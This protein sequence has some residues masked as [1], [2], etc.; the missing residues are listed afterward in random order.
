MNDTNANLWVTREA[1]AGARVPRIC[2]PT[3]RSFNRRAYQC[4][5]YEAQDVLAE[6]DDV[7]LI[8]LEPG[9]GFRLRESWQR[10]LVYRDASRRLVYL[11]PGLRR[12]T[13]EREYDLFVMVCQNHWDLLYVNAMGRWKDRCKVSVC[14]LDELWAAD[15]SSCK[16]WLHALRQFDHVFIGLWGTVGPLSEAI[17]RNCQW[18]PGAVDAFRFSPY[19]G[20]PSRSID[21]YSIGRRWEGMHEALL[22]AAARSGIFYIY[23]TFPAMANR[24]PYNAR[25]HRELFANMAKRTRFFVV[26]PAKMNLP[27]D[28]RGQVEIGYRYFEGAAAG[29]VMIGQVPDCD[30]FREAFPWPDAVVPV[31][32][33]GSDVVEIL[34]TLASDPARMARIGQRNAAE[35]LLRHDWSHRWREILA[36]AGIEP[37]KKMVSRLG[38]LARLADAAAA[39]EAASDARQAVEHP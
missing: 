34:E 20:T 21:V 39:D 38:D 1:S 33:D 19:P 12:V 28:T 4:S 25:E 3:A 29:T 30:A 36:V 16:Y 13:L 15:M 6:I 31:R 32:P 37:S 26:A 18:L 27:N 7:D 23:D 22:Q 24:D 11:N 14:W 5:L 2:M 35:A 8:H 17:D 10:R 9:P